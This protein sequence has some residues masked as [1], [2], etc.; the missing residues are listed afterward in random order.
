M[1]LSRRMLGAMKASDAEFEIVRDVR[2]P[3]WPVRL[4][5]W[6]VHVALTTA[7]ATAFA[8][9]VGWI[10]LFVLDIPASRLGLLSIAI[11]LAA[12]MGS[13]FLRGLYRR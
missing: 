4:G 1:G 8:V 13:A 3:A 5:R 11:I 2:R 10:G 12:T 7:I 6:L 9:F